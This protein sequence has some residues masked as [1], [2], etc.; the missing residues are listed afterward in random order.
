MV[1]EKGMMSFCFLTTTF[2]TFSFKFI[3]FFF[4]IFSQY[5]P[6]IIIYFYNACQ[7]FLSTFFIFFRRKSASNKCQWE[8]FFLDVSGVANG[9]GSGLSMRLSMGTV[10]GCQRGCQWGRFFLTHLFLVFDIKIFCCDVSKRTVPIDN[11]IDN[12]PLIIADN[13]QF[14]N[15]FVVF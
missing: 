9:D 10:V 6:Y 7:R 1:Q 14:F 5:I 4:R 12:I 8:W 2:C 15:F 13:F 3:K 11:L